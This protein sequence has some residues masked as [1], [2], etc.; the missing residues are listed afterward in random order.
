MRY[1][2]TR[3][4]VTCLCFFAVCTALYSGAGFFRAG[5]EKLTFSDEIQTQAAHADTI[6]PQNGLTPPV[7]ER[8][9]QHFARLEA[10]DSKKL[11]LAPQGREWLEYARAWFER[12]YPGEERYNRYVSLWVGKREKERLWRVKCREEFY[13]DFTEA[14]LIRKASWLQGQEEWLEMQ[15]KVARGLESIDLEYA[16]ALAE[17]MGDKTKEFHRLHELFLSESAFDE[18][19]AM[20][21]F[22]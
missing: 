16:G 7:A 5:A 14:E 19:P 15:E 3:F 18:R 21:F 6:N 4:W 8:L 17:L 22:L 10:R 20:N 2:D 11:A 13:P 9:G 1:L 12:V